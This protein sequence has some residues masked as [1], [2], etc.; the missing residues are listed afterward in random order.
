MSNQDAVFMA[1]ALKLAEKGCYTTDPNPRVGCVLVKDEQ[2]VA[3]GWHVKAGSAHAE[4]NA[5]NKID[6]AKGTTAYVTLEPCSHQGKTAPC[7][8]ALITAGIDRV[9]VA[10]QDPN[11]LVAGRGLRKM[12]DAGII[13]ECGV[14]QQQAEALNKG[15]IKRMT[16]GLP[17][18]RSKLAMS[19][20]GRTAMASGESQWITSPQ[21]RS[22]VQRLRA[23]SSAILTGINT[24]LEDNPSLNARVGEQVTL[25]VRV[26]LDSQ[27]KMPSNSKML[28]LPGQIWVLTCSDDDQKI[29]AL[30][31]T[32]YQVFQIREKDN[33]LD[34]QAVMFFLGEQQI[35]NVLV[36]AGAILNGALLSEK[37]VDEWI[38]Y[39]APCVLG[40]QGRGLFNLPDM[41]KMADKKQL[42]MT[43]VRQVGTDLKLTFET[44]K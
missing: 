10:M 12:Q 29:T 13:V 32:G 34:L 27:L 15:Y 18:V 16:T 1:M 39:M 35:N 44:A 31:K 30:E 40:D 11:P 9:V 4:I 22:D 6:N 7:C 26:I 17:F 33:K 36:E 37:L 28:E 24:V 2:L 19:L 43:S 20:D 8:D 21:S 38:L 14:L 23:E 41:Q 3:E 25:A 42:N 5:L